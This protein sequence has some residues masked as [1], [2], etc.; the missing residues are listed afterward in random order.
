MK[1]HGNAALSWSGQRLLAERVVVEGWTLTAALAA[2][3]LPAGH[4]R[5]RGARGHGRAR[6]PGEPLLGTDDLHCGQWRCELHA[7][8]PRR[9]RDDPLVR[10]ERI[11]T[12]R[13]QE[14]T[15]SV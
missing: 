4:A 8:I 1:L 7:Q 12:D 9:S 14:N 3:R 10:S 6:H 5:P 11:D 13:R 2:S 15:P